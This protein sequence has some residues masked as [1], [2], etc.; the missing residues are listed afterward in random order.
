MFVRRVDPPVK[1]A[2]RRGSFVAVSTS[3]P[4]A[5]N[6]VVVSLK[7]LQ[8]LKLSRELSKEDEEIRDQWKRMNGVARK[9]R[10]LP[11]LQE[12]YS[13]RWMYIHSPIIAA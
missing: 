3:A 11:T 9:V 12:L 2:S 10:Y 6:N 5:G 13:R 7:L 8:L 4:G 1:V